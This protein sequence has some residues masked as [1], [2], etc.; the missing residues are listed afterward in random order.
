MDNTTLKIKN[1]R[2]SISVLV[3][4]QK[5]KEEKEKIKEHQY[6]FY[7]FYPFTIVRQ[8]IIK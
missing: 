4:N 8:H 2:Y 5:N 3:F 7:L 6:S 1:D